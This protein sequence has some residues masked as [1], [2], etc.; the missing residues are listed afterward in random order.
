MEY[1]N[2]LQE[3]GYRLKK[4]RIKL[5]LTQKQLGDIIATK[6]DLSDKQIS[7]FECEEN[8]TR[9]D[10]LVELTIAL[11]KTPDYFLLGID[12]SDEYNDRIIDQIDEYLIQLPKEDIELVLTFVKTLNEKNN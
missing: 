6:F 2:Y 10:K 7:R 11:G 8:G 9:L 12:R 4:Q 5:G 1:K 3:V